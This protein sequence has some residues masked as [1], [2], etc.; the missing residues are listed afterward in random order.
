MLILFDHGAPGPLQLFLAGTLSGKERKAKADPS[1]HP[2]KARM[3]FGMTVLVNGAD[4]RV[5]AGSEKRGSREIEE[6][7]SGKR[8]E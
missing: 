1:H 3:G 4:A 7:D 6:R 8:Q 5:A 2:Q